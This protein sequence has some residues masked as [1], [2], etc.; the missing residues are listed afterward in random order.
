MTFRSGNARCA[1]LTAVMFFLLAPFVSAAGQMDSFYHYQGRP[2][3]P[4]PDP[5]KL[6]VE[7]N[8]AAARGA[9]GVW[10]EAIGRSI[11]PDAQ[12]RGELIRR[13]SSVL[14]YEGL[15]PAG[16]KAGVSSAMDAALSNDSV[17]R[18]FPVFI[19]RPPG[20]RS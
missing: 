5:A 6:A 2:V 11:A 20:A 3:R 4:T 8:P 9:A 15:A 1:G 10:P 17:S 12:L 7:L 13:H 18:V 16:A 19:N 14:L